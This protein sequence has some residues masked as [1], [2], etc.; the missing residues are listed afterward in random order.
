MD[1]TDGN[2]RLTKCGVVY[3]TDIGK[4]IECYVYA[5][6]FSVWDQADADNAENFMSHTGYLISYVGRTVFWYSKLQQKSI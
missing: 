2:W 5:D 1:L 6:L 3:K 4:V